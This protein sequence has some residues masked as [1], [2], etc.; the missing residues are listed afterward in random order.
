MSQEL[1]KKTILEAIEEGISSLGESPKQA[2]FFTLKTTFNIDKNEIPSNLL[3]FEQALKKIFGPGASYLEKLIIAH[4]YKK[5]GLSPQETH[6]LNL[7]WHVN[8]LKGQFNLER[9]K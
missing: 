2:I 5:L 8:N 6:Q 9:R 7:T 3:E 1:L 4:L